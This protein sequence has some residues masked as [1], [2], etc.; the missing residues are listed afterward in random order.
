MVLILGDIESMES[1]LNLPNHADAFTESVKTNSKKLIELGLWDMKLTRLEGWLNQF[2]GGEEQF[3]AACILSRVIFRNRQQFE[4]GLR[5]LFRSNLN[6]VFCSH[7][8]DHHLL[9]R[10]LTQPDPKIRLVPVIC[11]DDPPTKSGPLVMRRLQRILK[12]EPSYMCWPWQIKEDPSIEQVIF[13]DDFLGSGTQFKLFFEKWGF[14]SLPQCK[15]Y[16]YAPVVA[17]VKGLNYLEHELPVVEVVSAEILN[18]SHNFFSDKVWNQLSKNQISAADAENWYKTFFYTRINTS[19]EDMAHLGFS[20]MGLTFGFSHSTPDN[21][22][23]II[24]ANS[25]SWQPL[26]ER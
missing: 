21:S 25:S 14:D 10:L 26:L 7:Q 15:K 9:E 2:I 19:S 13:V 18:E 23:P 4:S 11:E 24:W 1:S 5:S 20:N 22:L 16:F 3:F 17:H 12:I 8:P 6:G